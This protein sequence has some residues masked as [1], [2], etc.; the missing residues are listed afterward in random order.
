MVEEMIIVS[1]L[2]LRD[3]DRFKERERLRELDNK[4]NIDFRYILDISNYGHV[5][6]IKK[7]MVENQ[8]DSEEESVFQEEVFEFEMSKTYISKID[9]DYFRKKRTL[10]MKLLRKMKLGTP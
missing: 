1:A 8:K 2:S 9:H 6:I 10:L 3:K 5:Y 4:L 7:D